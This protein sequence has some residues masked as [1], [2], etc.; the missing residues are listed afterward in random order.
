[1]LLMQKQ[2]SAGGRQKIQQIDRACA[3][4]GNPCRCGQPEHQQTAAADPAAG[5][6]AAEQARKTVPQRI[7]S[8]CLTAP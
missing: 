3:F 1:M 6:Y 2:R 5:E 7:H 4:P 8:S